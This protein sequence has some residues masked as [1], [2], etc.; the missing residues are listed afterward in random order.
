MVQVNLTGPNYQEAVETQDESLIRDKHQEYQSALNSISTLNTLVK[1]G[2]EILDKLSSDHFNK[3][4]QG[5]AGEFLQEAAVFEQGQ[6]A[7]ELGE[8]DPAGEPMPPNMDEAKKKFDEKFEDLVKAAP[9]AYR[10]A[11]RGKKAELRGKYLGAVEDIAIDERDVALSQMRSDTGTTEDTARLVS[12]KRGIRNIN[13]RYNAVQEAS[14]EY[15]TALINEEVNPYVAHG[16]LDEFIGKVNLVANGGTDDVGVHDLT[17]AT[18]KDLRAYAFARA[19]GQALSPNGPG[20]H[21]VGVLLRKADDAEKSIR[22]V[23]AFIPRL[24]PTD[25]KAI[26]FINVAKSAERIHNTSAGGLVTSGDISTVL[27]SLTE[28]V[29]MV[30]RSGDQR[31]LDL[32]LSTVFRDSTNIN[33][34]ESFGSTLVDLQLG[35]E[36]EVAL[37]PEGD[38]RT[39]IQSM[40]NSIKSLRG[41]IIV[42]ATSG[43]GGGAASTRTV[44]SEDQIVAAGG[45]K[46]YLNG[47]ELPSVTEYSH[48]WS[49]LTKETTFNQRMFLRAVY[50]HLTSMKGGDT[51]ENFMNLL[52]NINDALGAP[53]SIMMFENGNLRVLTPLENGAYRDY[54]STL[55]F[56]LLEGTDGRPDSLVLL[57]GPVIK[58]EKRAAGTIGASPAGAGTDTNGQPKPDMVQVSAPVEQVIAKAVE[59][60]GTVPNPERA[61]AVAEINRDLVALAVELIKEEREASAGVEPA[62]TGETVITTLILARLL[63]KVGGDGRALRLLETMVSQD[64]GGLVKSGL[65]MLEKMTRNPNPAAIKEFLTNTPLGKKVAANLGE[66]AL[67]TLDFQGGAEKVRKAIKKEMWKS[68]RGGL[69]WGRPITTGPFKVLWSMAK[70]TYGHVLDPVGRGV[71]SRIAKSAVG[72]W[73]GSEFMKHLRNPMTIVK[74]MWRLV[75]LPWLAAEQVTLQAAYS[76]ER[77]VHSLGERAGEQREIIDKRGVDT[78]GRSD[79]DVLASIMHEAGATAT[80]TFGF[81]TDRLI[82]D[83]GP[84]APQGFDEQMAYYA[85]GIANFVTTGE[86]NP[87]AAALDRAGATS[88]LVKSGSYT[89]VSDRLFEELYPISPKHKTN[90]YRTRAEGFNTDVEE[91]QGLAANLGMLLPYHPGEPDHTDPPESYP[92]PSGTRLLGTNKRWNEDNTYITFDRADDSESFGSRLLLHLNENPGDHEAATL[93][94]E[95]FSTGGHTH[96]NVLTLV[97]MLPQGRLSVSELFSAENL[98]AAGIAALDAHLG[99]LS[100]EASQPLIDSVLPLGGIVGG[101]QIDDRPRPGW[102]D[103]K[104]MLDSLVAGQEWEKLGDLLEPIVSNPE[105]H[106]YFKS[107]L[108]PMPENSAMIR[109]E[110]LSLNANQELSWKMVPHEQTYHFLV[111]RTLKERMLETAGVDPVPLDDVERAAAMS[112]D[113]IEYQ[114]N[115]L[116]DEHMRGWLDPGEWDEM[117]QDVATTIEARYGANFDNLNSADG[118]SPGQVVRDSTDRLKVSARLNAKQDELASSWERLSG[119]AGHYGDWVTN[120][121]KGSHENATLHPSQRGRASKLEVKRTI[122]RLDDIILGME[123]AAKMTEADRAGTPGLKDVSFKWHETPL[124]YTGHGGFTIREAFVTQDTQ[125]AAQGQ[126][127]L[128][129][130]AMVKNEDGSATRKFISIIKLKRGVEILRRHQRLTYL[131]EDLDS[132]NA[133]AGAK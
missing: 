114:E 19:E 113:W 80:G 53:D 122:E 13:L 2:G 83:S 24:D 67:E 40:L 85:Y 25:T 23:N 81:S 75:S 60:M 108:P 120:A 131:I 101:E 77:G 17:A 39:A 35:Y 88:H 130:S 96:H 124:D 21:A 64:R 127:H 20:T 107:L 76:A 49:S 97:D 109:I 1:G 117:A 99:S 10:G 48:L 125:R 50:S 46:D 54:F 56:E 28:H 82:T 90:A 59:A 79:L 9:W 74:G 6:S 121:L 45:I 55:Q 36:R 78:S 133:E 72:K 106:T 118:R 51:Q 104:V 92:E 15:G 33:V 102:A 18:E 61:S 98:T 126:G 110:G 100:L 37:L 3:A 57:R 43:K 119:E 58:E 63:G 93:A 16:R 41:R 132:L 30:I 70:G 84:Y 52:A 68:I 87:R 31:S 89:E 128:R 105:S 62:R 69:K 7:S 12:W 116:T 34:N 111:W 8:L 73:V 129:F 115:A 91:M 123:A 44:P 22:A 26:R 47:K 11:L 103:I 4:L 95:H 5:E 32:L 38:T 65:S 71:G 27:N 29:D 14:L 112:S 94:K 86:T 66:A 42:P